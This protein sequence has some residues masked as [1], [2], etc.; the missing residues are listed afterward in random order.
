MLNVAYFLFCVS[1]LLRDQVLGETIISICRHNTAEKET[2]TENSLFKSL[3]LK[4]ELFLYDS[5]VY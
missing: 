4:S 1:T 5:N 2:K 3:L